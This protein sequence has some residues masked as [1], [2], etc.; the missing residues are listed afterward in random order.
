VKEEERREMRRQLG[1]S[2]ARLKQDPQAWAAY[3][4]ELA[5][6]DGTIA[7]GLVDGEWEEQWTHR[8]AIAR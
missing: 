4:A 2:V 3:Q 8:D 7:D 6:T 1:E 5:E